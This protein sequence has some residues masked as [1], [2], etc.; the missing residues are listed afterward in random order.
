MGTDSSLASSNTTR[1]NRHKQDH[2]KFHANTQNNFFTVRVMEL[3]NKLL[4]EVVESP[5]VVTF[6][7]YLDTYLCNL[8]QGF[9]FSSRAGLHF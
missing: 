9:C 6:K 3:Q 1:G 5:S 4:R 2:R 8:L 7:T